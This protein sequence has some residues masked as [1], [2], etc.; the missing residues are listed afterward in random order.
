MNTNLEHLPEYKR[1]ELK[2]VVAIIRDEIREKELE[3][4]ILFGS[5]ARGTWVEDA[6]VTP[7]GYYYKYHSDFDILVV[8]HRNTANKAGKWRRL[9]D[10][11]RATPEIQTPV[12]LIEHDIGFVN[13]RLT[14][15]NYF[16]G[17]ILKEGIL[18]YDAG[19]RA[20][21]QPRELT[22]EERL[23]QA[24]EDFEYWFE[25]A[26]E[27]LIGFQTYLDK[28]IYK[29]AAFLLH[30]ATEHFYTA[31]LLVHTGYKPHT[32]DLEKLNNEAALHE[33]AVRAV[34]PK[35]SEEEERLFDL[36]RKAYVDARYKKSYKIT[37]EELEWLC[38]RVQNLQELTEKSCRAKIAAY[39]AVAG[40]KL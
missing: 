23:K 37:H 38:E 14:E 5:H 1:K 16:F 28:S 6:G 35:Q 29:K 9:R 11:I 30:Q 27:F 8:A 3:K 12:S 19:R 31:L 25:S 17:D 15:G 13:Q 4:V 32:H 34:F 2:E 21:K 10:R 39:A 22:P 20:F 33:H 40:R 24:S 18:L 36:L 7:N 26:G